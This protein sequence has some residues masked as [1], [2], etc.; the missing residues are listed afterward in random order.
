MGTLISCW[1]TGGEQSA[2]TYQ[3]KEDHFIDRINGDPPLLLID[4][5]E[6]DHVGF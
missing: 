2:F 4:D 5:I 1:L 3:E 6:P